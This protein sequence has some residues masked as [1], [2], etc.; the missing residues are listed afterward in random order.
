MATRSPGRT[1][2]LYCHSG[3]RLDFGLVGCHHVHLIQFVRQAAWRRRRW[4]ED[5]QDA[6]CRRGLKGGGDRVQWNF[7][8]NNKHV[9]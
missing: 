6:S 1:D 4:V 7:K 3:Q 8:L 9:G 5:G 2:V